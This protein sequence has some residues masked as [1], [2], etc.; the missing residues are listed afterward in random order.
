[1]PDPP[2]TAP[3]RAERDRRYARLRAAMAEAELDGLLAYA[4]AW[5]RENVRYLTGAP[6]RAAF[7]FAYLP[8][9]G[10]PTAFAASEEDEAAIAAA[11]LCPDVCR[12]P[13]LIDR[14]R[15]NAR[16]GVAHAELV[17]A[18]FWDKLSRVARLQSATALM[19]RVRLVKSDWEIAQIR[20][21]AE[22]CD[23]GWIT[24]LETLRPGIAEY[25][26][27]AE[28]EASLKAQGAEDNFMIIAS[29]GA[30]VRGMTPPSDRRLHA[31]DMVRTELTPQCNGYWAQ[32]CRSAVVGKASA[33]Q[34]DS[35]ALFEEAVA[36]GLDAVRP[37][38]TAHD[39]AKA[40]NDVFRQHG[41]G[42]Y[43]TSEY[44]RVRG[45]GHGL[46]IDEFPIVEGAETVLE[47]GAV[48]I[49][50]PNTYTP[51]AGYHVLGDP[52]VVTAEGHEPLL[53][54]PRELT[55]VGA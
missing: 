36:A 6:L 31:G 53:R 27:V 44:T 18:V 32:I 38:A 35:F 54:T 51:I 41:L 49:V 15:G 39:V 13:E 12:I 1:M 10:E 46:H 50:H 52:I 37:G 23:A 7:A 43:C 17:P 42:E 28:V 3:G 22:V 29:G 5:R 2:V 25:E 16:I 20:R 47:P 30:E 9:T 19:D 48:A 8:A 40:E 33:E 21:C 14:L 34:R 55:E 24:F 45:H 11:G 4:P 26:I